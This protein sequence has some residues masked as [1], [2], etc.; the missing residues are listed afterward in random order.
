MT[1]FPGIYLICICVS[2]FGEFIRE[3]VALKERQEAPNGRNIARLLLWCLVFRIQLIVHWFGFLHIVFSLFFHLETCVESL[4]EERV[5]VPVRRCAESVQ[6]FVEGK[7]QECGTSVETG[8][9]DS[10]PNPH[11]PLVCISVTVCRAMY[12]LHHFIFIF[13]FILIFLSAVALSVH[14]LHRVRT[15]FLLFVYHTRECCEP[16]W[17]QRGCM[18]VITSTPRQHHA[19]TI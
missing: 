13:C 12:H 14:I 19:V 5:Q 18:D 7:I 6:I 1:S 11:I 16:F 9:Y 8:L 2:Q 17:E 10:Y 15:S 3:K 4:H